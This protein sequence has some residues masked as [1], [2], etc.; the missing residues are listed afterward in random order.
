MINH[1]HFMAA[2]SAY[3]Q[4][5]DP[6]HIKAREEGERYRAAWAKRELYR[7]KRIEETR[8]PCCGHSPEED[9]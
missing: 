3:A 8:C 5:N 2:V 6:E 1:W 7:L 4:R 9:E